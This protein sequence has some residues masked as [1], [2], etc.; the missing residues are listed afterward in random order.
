M[1]VTINVSSW[2][3]RYT[4]G[5]SCIEKEISDNETALEAVCSTGIPQDEIGFI[6]V[7][8]KGQTNGE[9]PHIADA[10]VQCGYENHACV[11]KKVDETY[12]VAEGDVL[13]VYPF[14]IGG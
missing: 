9:R 10:E 11:E 7:C 12:V 4:G 1:K 6:T 14:I 8:S 13:R 3:K 2:F 5:L